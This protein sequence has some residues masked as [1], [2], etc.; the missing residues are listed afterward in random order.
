MIILEIINILI[1][2]I[3]NHNDEQWLLTKNMDIKKCKRC[4]R[5][6]IQYKDEHRNNIKKEI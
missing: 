5:F 1:C 2:W 3:K 6:L 4:G